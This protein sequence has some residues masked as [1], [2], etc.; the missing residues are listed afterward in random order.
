MNAARAR[1]ILTLESVAAELAGGDSLV[2]C[3]QR[4]PRQDFRSLCAPLPSGAGRRWP[5]AVRAP[6]SDEPLALARI[7]LAAGAD[8]PERLAA[9]L[10]QLALDLRE[11]AE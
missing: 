10:G 6:S 2:Q 1:L 5:W 8:T 7:A 3:L 9:S 4:L 11:G